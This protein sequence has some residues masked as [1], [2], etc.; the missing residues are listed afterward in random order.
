MTSQHPLY[1][2]SKTL[3][4][5]PGIYIIRNAQKQIIYI[6][7]AKK[8]RNRVSQYFRSGAQHDEKTARMV[9]AA[10]E[11]D[12]IVTS[13]EFEALVL[14]C[15][16]I[17]QH[18]P[19]YNVLLKDDKGYRYI[20]ISKGNWPR[21]SAEKQHS[22][23]DATWL[24]P[25]MS[26][27]AVNQ[28][29]QTA[30]DSFLLPR[31][32][33]RFPQ[34]FG[35]QRPCLYA[36][37]GR[38]MAVCSGKISREQYQESVNSALALIRNTG[39]EVLQQLRDKM[40]QASERLEFER[41]ALLRDQIAAIEKLRDVQTVVHSG[42]KNQ[43]VIA[44]AQGEGSVCAAVLRIRSG[45]LVDKREFLF[46]NVGTLSAL[47]EEFLP[48]YYLSS[49]EDI[50]TEIAV[51][52][53]LPDQELVQQLLAG[54]KNGNV[55]IYT[56][57]RGDGRK[58]M[59]TAY[60]NAIERLAQESGRTRKEDKAL[61]ELA[62]I[63]GLDSVPSTIESYDISNWGEGTSVCGMVVFEGGKPKKSGYRRF[64]IQTV[65]GTDDYASI[66]EALLRR[67]A[68]YDSGAAGQ[69]GQMPSLIFIDGG[70][71]QVR[72]AMAV[73]ADTGLAN[74]PLFGM[75]KDNRHRTRGLV[76]PSGQE[77]TL[78]MHRA[79]FTLVSTIQNE[80]HRFAISYQRKN[81]KKS[82][83]SSSL[84]GING[85]GPATAKALMAH[86]KTI[87]AIR[88]ASMQELALAKGVNKSAAKAI[89]EH[90]N[91]N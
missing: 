88:S 69:F 3:P 71:G 45:H 10:R 29:V 61:S 89:F 5:L 13:S 24:G 8:L 17:K 81:A 85:I 54:Q 83:L 78:S 87:S 63:L 15:Q 37:I 75:V 80:T 60:V 44:F 46:S 82:A 86:F 72:A 12:V 74:V 53:P 28:S 42:G 52:E 55:R 68:E 27:Y 20:K 50:P 39:G 59:Q 14:E 16:Q 66:S 91:A 35:K 30:L 51:D 33:R 43:D 31:C 2:K 11:L 79:P 6:G 34:D 23:E 84:L 18:R 62:G 25:Y 90:F 76:S 47:R 7:K 22:G 21:I 56:P 26:S 67:A 48:Q 36:H 57:Q 1:Q 73:L 9:E 38:C 77:T 4:L 40:E 49:S 32:S 65:S 41:A 19:K 70:L 64:K 58:L